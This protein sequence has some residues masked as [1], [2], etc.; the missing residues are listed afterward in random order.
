MQCSEYA[1][2]C[3]GSRSQFGDTSGC[4]TIGKMWFVVACFTL[5]PLIVLVKDI[6]VGC[7]LLK[8]QLSLRVYV[9]RGAVDADMWGQCGC[10]LVGDLGGRKHEGKPRPII[11]CLY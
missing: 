6:C 4:L 5:G 9:T 2:N 3:M 11:H 8:V 7:L 10:A 1:G